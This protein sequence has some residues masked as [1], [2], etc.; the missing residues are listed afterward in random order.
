[1]IDYTILYRTTL[2]LDTDWLP[3]DQWDF[4]VSAYNKSQRVK[5]VF[6]KVVA[7]RKVWVVHPEYSLSADQLPP[8]AFLPRSSD[9]AE[10]SNSVLDWYAADLRGSSICLD[11]TGMMRPHIMVFVLLLFKRGVQKFDV[12]YSEPVHYSKHENTQFSILPVETVR[13][14]RGFEGTHSTDTDNDLL[15]IGSGY[16]DA[17]I[18]RV[19]EHKRSARKLQIFGLP[20]LRPDMYQQNALQA[21]RAAESVGA[22]GASPLHARFAPANDPFVTA[23]VLQSIVA[24]ENRIRPLTNLYLCPLATKPQT[25]GFALYYLMEQEDKAASILFPF[26]KGYA[27]ETSIG[28]SRIWK[29]TVE[30]LS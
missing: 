23:S 30:R 17:L 5:A 4:F 10:F 24:G 1:M 14:V 21:R 16:D 6:E 11:I 12:L 13:P 7:R 29:Y 28:L 27:S 19:A 15:V 25:L 3:T 8:E 9:E 26:A 20:S 18:A 2:P 22:I